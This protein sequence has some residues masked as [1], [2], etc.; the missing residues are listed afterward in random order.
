M[1]DNDELIDRY[2]GSDQDEELKGYSAKYTSLYGLVDPDLDNV[3]VGDPFDPSDPTHE[4]SYLL[5]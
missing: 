5:T 3:S 4:E 1:L 2:M